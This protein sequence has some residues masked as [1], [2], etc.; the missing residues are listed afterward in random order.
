[1]VT[2]STGIITTVAGSAT[3]GYSGDGGQAILAELMNPEGVTVDASGNIHIADT[4]NCLIRMVTKS[5]GIISL[6]AGT[7]EYGYSGDGGQATLAVM[8]LPQN[9][10]VDASGNVYITDADIRRIRMVTK[11]TGIITTVAG[12][13]A[14]GN[15]GDG[16]QATSAQLSSPRLEV[17]LWMCLATCILLILVMSSEF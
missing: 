8:A 10:A 4:D 6:V 2:K 16:L 13:G 11:N 15:M 1:M 9:I 17:L 7:G 3:A 5:T 14:H 12:N